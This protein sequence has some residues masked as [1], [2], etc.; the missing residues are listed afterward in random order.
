MNY[1]MG[2]H[3]R[4]LGGHDC[5]S[6]TM[7]GIG[8]ARV[9][10]QLCCTI[11]TTSLLKKTQALSTLFSQQL[12]LY[13]SLK[14]QLRHPGLHPYTTHIRKMSQ[15]THSWLAVWGLHSTAM[16]K[17]CGQYLVSWW[18]LLPNLV[19]TIMVS[20]QC[21]K[22]VLWS[23][24]LRDI[25]GVVRPKNKVAKFLHVVDGSSQTF[26]CFVQKAIKR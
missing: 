6:T 3:G 4:K 1:E 21:L 12:S 13:E 24:H 5:T 19:N 10:V 22:V 18:A 9:K 25:S 20:L 11:T 15:Y 23:T 16:M 7:Y 8:E 2:S 14:H 26:R 17:A